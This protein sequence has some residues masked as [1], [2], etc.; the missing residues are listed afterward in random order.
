MIPSTAAR[1][2]E[3]SIG[4][5]LKGPVICSPAWPNKTTASV[6][7]VTTVHVIRHLQEPR[8]FFFFGWAEKFVSVPEPHLNSVL[9]VFARFMVDSGEPAVSVPHPHPH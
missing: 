3:L 5:T 8:L 9:S 6:A 2:S 7:P 4:R 1:T